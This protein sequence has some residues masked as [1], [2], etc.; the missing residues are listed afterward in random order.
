M[1]SR[2]Q[3]EKEVSKMSTK[4]EEVTVNRVALDNLIKKS[5]ELDFINSAGVRGATSHQKITIDR[6]TF[7][8]LARNTVELHELYNQ[9]VMGWDGYADIDWDAV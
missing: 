2:V 4:P 8:T 1:E 7:N 5:A 6:S 9:G 3:Q